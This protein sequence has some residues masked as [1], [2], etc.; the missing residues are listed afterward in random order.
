MKRELY[1]AFTK[2]LL[3]NNHTCRYFWVY[4]RYN[5]MKQCVP[6]VADPKRNINMDPTKRIENVN[7]VP[8]RMFFEDLRS[9]FN[10]LD[11]FVRNDPTLK[12]MIV[13]CKEFTDEKTVMAVGRKG[14]WNVRAQYEPALDRVLVGGIPNNV[15]LAYAS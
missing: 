14:V 13:D 8:L 5:D 9:W 11:E 7:G 10:L 15:S 4:Y 1:S 12:L 2:E 6:L 3:E